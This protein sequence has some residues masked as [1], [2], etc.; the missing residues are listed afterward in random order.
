MSLRRRILMGLTGV[1]LVSVVSLGIAL[2]Y[3]SPCGTAAPLPADIERMQAVRAH[4]YGPPSVLQLEDVAKPAISDDQVLVKVRAASVNP[5]D[6]H[7]MRGEPY[8]MRL[9]AGL[10]APKESLLGVDYAGTVEAV[11]KNVTRFKPGD[12][13]FGGR[14]GALGEYV[15]V[16]HDRNIVHM[17]ENVTF[18]EAAGVHVAALT[19]LQGLRDQGQLQA[20]QKVLINGA[21]GGVG[22]FAIQIAKSMGA[23]VTAVCSTR[24]L[25]LVR[26]LGA[27]L[28]IDYT[29][30]NF[31]D[32]EVQ[33]DMILDNVS[34]QSLSDMRRVLKPEGRLVI[35]G[36]TSR[37][38]WIG[39]LW[40]VLKAYL[41]SN[42]V[43]QPMGMF[44]SQANPA[45]L[46]TLA[47]LLRE[48]KMKTVIDR[49]FPLSETAAAIEYLETGRARGKVIVTV[50][51]D[52]AAARIS[53][54]H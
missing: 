31:T 39:P 24:N 48:G 44:I 49:R 12:R 28:T 6:W 26:S 23:E 43:D 30:E 17:P 27:D 38:P 13:V 34:T 14:N 3:E 21:S 54:D 47:Q 16:R 2:S 11:G 36:G 15:P 52:S 41:L 46:A 5:V 22:T 7:F 33:Y 19:A 45:D 51:Q 40:P 25:E 32:R 50:D 4:C 10:G 9:D 1:L 20:G 18:D 42:F 35:V 29:Q 53:A 37:D 8:L